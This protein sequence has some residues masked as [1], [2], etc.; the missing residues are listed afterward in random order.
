MRKSPFALLLFVIFIMIFAGCNSLAPE[1]T[2]IPQVDA[3]TSVEEASTPEP[4]PVTG[5][6]PEDTL[7]VGLLL[8]FSG[9]FSWV[10]DH[11]LPVMNMIVA[12]VNDSGGIGGAQVNLVQAD[13]AGT[14]NTGLPAAEKLINEDEIVALLG[15]TSLLFPGMEELI[16][17]HRLAM[18]SPT[19]GTVDLDRAGTDYFYRTV[20]SDSLGGRVIARA[21]SAPDT[22]LEGADVERVVLLIAQDP[23]F[24]SFRDPIE[25]GMADFGADLA[26]TVAYET[27]KDEYQSEIEQV[28]AEQPQMVILVGTPDD[29]ALLM[30]TAV[31][32]G[33]EGGWFATQDQTNPE[34]I[35]LIGNDLANEVYGLE[36]VA[37]ANA[38]ERTAVFE[39]RLMAFA[40]VAPEIFAA[41]SYDAANVLFLAMTRTALVDGEVNRA[42]I[43]ENIPLVANPGDGKLEVGNYT[44]G[45][46]ALE[47]GQEIAYVGLNG[48]IDFDEYGNITAPFGIFQV[49][50]GQWQ[51]ISLIEANQ[52]R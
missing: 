50:D 26:A 52:A 30:Q 47:A 36:E 44:D 29:A 38:A 46:R 45:K 27:G 34:F 7:P 21:I 31:E 23:A 49:Q 43:N 2:A 20:P 10:G 22:Y 51:M 4:A 14:P 18:V 19:A 33:Y 32:N 5:D 24:I 15:P 11:A 39:E 9:Q 12:E 42:T 1:P 41:T 40:G 37:D 28:L 25:N 17:E 13:S 35:A 16:K 48:P 3:P 8:P 6:A